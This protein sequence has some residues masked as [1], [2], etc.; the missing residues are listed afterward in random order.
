MRAAA[1]ERAEQN[2]AAA[3]IAEARIRELQMQV[4]LARL[5]GHDVGLDRRDR[6]VEFNVHNA[7]NRLPKFDERN[8]VDSYLS[9]FEKIAVT[10]GWPRDKWCAI[11]HPLLTGKAQQAFD[12]LTI[13]EI[14]NYDMLKRMIL[15]AYELV[16]EAYRKRFRTCTKRPMDN[17]TDFA[18]F[19]EQSLL[20]WLN[21]ILNNMNYDRLLQVILLEQFYD[22]VSDD[23]KVYLMDKNFDNVMEAARKADE[24]I[25]LHKLAKNGNANSN[26]HKNSQFNRDNIR[27]NV[28]RVNNNN[29]ATT[30]TNFNNHNY[31]KAQPEKNIIVCYYCKM[32]GHLQK[33][34][35]KRKQD[36]VKHVTYVQSELNIN[37][38]MQHNSKPV[39]EC[40]NDQSVAGETDKHVYP[41]CV[42]GPKPASCQ[43]ML[44]CY[45]DTGANVCILREGSVPLEYLTPLN[46]TIDLSGF[47]GGSNVS[48]V[49]KIK[50]ESSVVKGE[51]VV[52]MAPSSC[53]FPRNCS[54]IV[55]EDY[56]EPYGLLQGVVNPVI[57]RQQQRAQEAVQVM[58][59]PV[60]VTDIHE[61]EPTIIS[62]K[63][64]RVVN[65]DIDNEDLNEPFRLLFENEVASEENVSEA[66]ER[67]VT[68]T[69]L[70]QLQRQDATLS[71]VFE[72]LVSL[73]ESQH[74]QGY[75]INE[76]GLLVR[77]IGDRL[78]GD[79]ADKVIQII[80][81]Y[82]L[83]SKILKLSHAIPASGHLGVNKTV[84]RICKYFN[85]PGLR[86]D[87]KMYCLS[88]DTCQRVRKCGKPVRVPMQLM[89]VIEKPFS[90]VSCDV[91]G[92]LN[93]TKNGNK[94]ILTVVDHATRWAEA[95]CLADHKAATISKCMCDFVSRFGI[96]DEILHD[97]GADFTSE[98]FSVF[99]N[100][101][102][103]NQL[104][105]SVAHPQTNTA[106]ERFNG[107]LKNML[108]AFVHDIK[109]DWDEGINY[110]LF[111]YRELPNEELGFSPFELTYGRDVKGPLAA[112]YNTWWES[113][114]QKASE[115]VIDYMIKQR[116]FLENAL[117][118][119]S[120]QRKILQ[121]KNKLWYDKNARNK[122][123]E[124]GDLVLVLQTQ[125]GKPLSLHYTGPYKILSKTSQVNYLVEFGGKRKPQRVIHV[126][127]LRPYV[128][129]TEF[130]NTINRPRAH[131]V[132]CCEAED[133]D[134]YS[135][136]TFSQ[137]TDFSK[138]L[139][140]KMEHLPPIFAARMSNLVRK[141]EK[142]FSDK[143][144]CVTNYEHEIRLKP[145]ST[146][147]AQ[148]PYRMSPENREK[149][150]IEINDL[151][152][153]GLIEPSQS[154]WA[155]PAILVPKSDGSMRCVIDYRKVNNIIQGDSFPMQR[156]DDL[157]DKIGQ[158]KYLT[159]IDLCK[160]FY[161]ISLNENSREV[162][163]FC[164]PFGCYKWRRLPFG[165]KTSS[166][167][168][169]SMISN[170]LSGL[171]DICGMYVDDVI[172]FSNTLDEHVEHCNI[173]FERLL[174]ANLTVKLIK[175]VFACNELEYVGHI[176]GFGQISPKQLK[177]KSILDAPRPQS[178]KQLQS[179]LGLVGFYQRYLPQYSLLTAP[180]TD[181]LKKNKYFEWNDNADK[182]FNDI[183]MLMS[184][185]P[186]LIIAD[187]TKP[188]VLYVDASE[189]AVG[190]VLMQKDNYDVLRPVCYYSKKLNACQ[191][192][193]A[194]TEKEALALIL[195]IRAFR[196]YLSGGHTL[197][198]TDHEPL[199]FVHSNAG[200]SQ[201]LLR[202]SMELQAFD[203]E[204]KHIPGSKNLIADYL[205]RNVSTVSNNDL[206]C[207]LHG[208]NLTS[209]TR[210]KRTTMDH[211]IN[212]CMGTGCS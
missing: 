44:T 168:F 193:Y 167:S 41:V 35:F 12:K 30:S 1:A 8:N 51:I 135:L 204:I 144:G 120:N 157:I 136:L 132:A 162:T 33:D 87:V 207:V 198:Y 17:Y 29:N 18:Q 84:K 153:L 74:K 50:V 46:R 71:Q 2:A 194:I 161:Q 131:D 116:T 172:I 36:N 65:Q 173:V 187:F 206:Y 22:R 45:R 24:Y 99:L 149:L 4:E 42:Y 201:R 93:I 66:I 192:N 155:S 78:K 146:P 53:N 175:C 91:I 188:F 80:V 177:V 185:S 38:C 140:E 16:P 212:H 39:V 178:K 103:I 32:P 76:N 97:L 118:V 113:G 20:K 133:N 191:R 183:K 179:L 7:T 9:T 203:L 55:G 67:E 106:V 25:T 61:N 27:P 59:P 62:E 170:V 208:Q 128:Q 114:E 148:R 160:G 14:G 95:Y 68:T 31:A 60:P 92:P 119:V 54:L 130:V 180:L 109:S 166:A 63:I 200:H 189:I 3:V 199:K 110:V 83:R 34:C 10:D 127:L 112:V 69:R 115:H 101:F 181:L 105:C 82:N 164:T 176:V 47:Y 89:P 150:R 77:A 205:S 72:E 102:G 125:P 141:Y 124:I 28:N 121:N 134:P 210:L 182:A 122:T 126:N 15:Q 138:L 52:A 129:R 137:G 165:L 73:N 211:E 147:I 56:G 37:A 156:I 184:T 152:K 197:V 23:L 163:T 43:V 13:D 139:N 58:S 108:T 11:L 64:D 151:I 104:R 48:P 6:P 159:K 96:P 88:C 107:T 75:C 142:V 154:E 196:I 85:W 195:S 90:R 21:S 111:A 70:S 86:K 19:L 57:T 123:Y 79:Q 81:P 5:R 94:F 158:A 40:M 145:N 100:Y 49:Y 209:N 169:N 26:V 174:N 171:E 98:L 190:S 143:P 117:S 186:T 202:W